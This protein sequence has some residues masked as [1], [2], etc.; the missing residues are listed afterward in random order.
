MVFLSYPDLAQRGIKYN[1]SHLWRMEREGKF[2]KRVQMSENRIAWI[3]TEIDEW[4][5]NRAKA[6]NAVAA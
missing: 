6:R 3:D 4:Q 1:R 5:K 2:P